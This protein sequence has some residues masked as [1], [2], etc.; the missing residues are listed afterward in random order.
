MFATITQN[1][2]ERVGKGFSQM[3]VT[4]KATSYF[5]GLPE[6]D[7]PTK[8]QATNEQTHGEANPSQNRHRIKIHPCRIFWFICKSRFNGDICETK[9]TNLFA[10][11][12]CKRNRKRKGR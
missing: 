8:S 9:N 1:P 2:P 3:S 10:K 4:G 7:V 12:E 6:W 5:P 11:K